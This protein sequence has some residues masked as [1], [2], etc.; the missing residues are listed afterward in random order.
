MIVNNCFLNKLLIGLSFG[1]V[2]FFVA[3]TSYMLFEIEITIKELWLNFT[4]SL[5]VGIYFSTASVIFDNE[6][7]S[8]LKQTSI[9]FLTSVAFFFPIAILAKWVPV[10]PSPLII[11]F[12]CFL[13]IYSFI[14]LIFYFHFKRIE[15]QLN[16][17]L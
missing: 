10:E 1:A 12:L 14:Y 2:I 16:D 9:H 3:L 4:G 15:R 6:K 17:L 7:W 13:I 5:L 8:T 11:C